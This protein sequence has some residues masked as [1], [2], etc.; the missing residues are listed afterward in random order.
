MKPSN[1]APSAQEVAVKIRFPLADGRTLVQGP[2]T[3]NA[4][5]L[6]TQHNA[7]FLNDPRFAVAYKSGMETIW[8][9]RPGL[10]VAFRVYIACWAASHGLNLGGD[11]VECGVFTGIYSRA[12]VDYVNFGTLDRTFYLCDTFDGIPEDQLTEEER[13]IGLQT[14]NTKYRI[15][16]FESVQKTFA[17]FPNVKLIKGPVPDTLEHV[18]AEKIAYLSIDMNAVYPE[19]SAMEALWD[20]VV[21]GAII[22]LDDYG[23]ARHREQKKA[24]DDFARKKKVEILT[25]PTGQG[26]IIKP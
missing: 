18:K 12:I 21:P 8:T 23:W 25:L 3:Y 6:A 24:H 26:L 9:R 13:R 20:R 14:M 22:L 10:D 4:D 19:I 17:P 2:L 11:F 5:G 15:G 16:I 1:A 7:D